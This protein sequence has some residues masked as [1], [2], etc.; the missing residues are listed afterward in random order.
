MLFGILPRGYMDPE[1]QMQDD[2]MS[3]NESAFERAAQLRQ[4]SLQASQ[5]EQTDRGHRDSPV[6]NMTNDVGRKQLFR[7]K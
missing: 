1:E 5:A 6:E 7:K 4:I 2:G 3:P